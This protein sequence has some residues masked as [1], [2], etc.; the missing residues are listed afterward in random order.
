MMK[1][2]L[3]LPLLLFAQYSGSATFLPSEVSSDDK[4]KFVP[5]YEKIKSFDELLQQF[6]GR[7]VY[8]DLWATWCRPC[9]AQF[10]YKDD[11]NAFVKENDIDVLYIS[12]DKDLD[13]DK[14]FEFIEDKKLSGYHMRA[15]SR[16][17][18]EIRERFTRERDGRRLFGIPYY[19]IAK[20]GQITVKNAPRP[21]SK[22]QLYKELKKHI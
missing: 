22:D 6:K 3:F 21:S 1:K 18:S 5:K 8:I 14:W 7:T 19:I 16:L 2:F 20:D 17:A 11:L 12:M 13:D 10:E 4:V 15:S 9:I